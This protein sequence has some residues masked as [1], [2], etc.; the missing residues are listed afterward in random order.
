M[1]S[2]LPVLASSGG[3]MV[4]MIDDGRT[5]WVASGTATAD[6]SAALTR[7]LAAPPAA[8]MEMGRAASVAIRGICDNTRTVDRQLEFRARLVTEGARR[9]LRIPVP[10]PPRTLRSTSTPRTPLEFGHRPAKP[11]PAEAARTAGRGISLVVVHEPGSRPAETVASLRRQLTPPASV[12]VVERSDLLRGI[13]LAAEAPSLGIAIVVEGCRLS[14]HFLATCESVLMSDDRIGLVSS[15]YGTGNDDHCVTVRPSPRLPYQ[16]RRDDVS[17]CCAMR[18]S[19]VLRTRWLRD[20]ATGDVA[21]NDIVLALL[22]DGWVAVNYPEVLS[23]EARRKTAPREPS[24]ALIRGP[25]TPDAIWR[26]PAYE[27]LQLVAR[28][29][30]NPRYATRWLSWHGWSALISMYERAV[31]ATSGAW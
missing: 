2:G 4:E 11:G 18:T 27:Q 30:R 21:L 22:G 28:A 23:V 15:W 17:S 1:C 12:V 13:R 29:L 14:P 19:G 6:L 31:R 7:A 20:G 24:D 25:V 3:G 8:W 26:L 16:G 10:P 5:G 9:S